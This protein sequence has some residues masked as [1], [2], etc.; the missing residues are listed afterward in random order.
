M[1]RE[2]EL[3]TGDHTVQ[4]SYV[5]PGYATGLAIGLVGFLVWIALLLISRRPPRGESFTDPILVIDAE[6]VPA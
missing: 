1:L 6:A 2:L 5:A 4:F 3:P